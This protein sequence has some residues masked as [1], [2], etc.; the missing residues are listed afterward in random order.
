MTTMKRRNLTFTILI[1]YLMQL[2]LFSALAKTE[3]LIMD[4]DFENGGEWLYGN[5]NYADKIVGIDKCS[6]AAT[7]PQH[8]YIEGYAPES[9]SGDKALYIKNVNPYYPVTFKA[10]LEC[11]QL[12]KLSAWVK[13]ANGEPKMN[14]AAT[15]KT[16][17]WS[18][19]N[20]IFESDDSN[21]E[22]KYSAESIWDD[23][24][25]H[26][27]SVKD[28][29]WTKIERIFYVAED[30]NKTAITAWIG[31]ASYHGGFGYYIDDVS[32]TKAEYEVEIT[33]EENVSIPMFGEDNTIVEYAMSVT[34]GGMN[35]PID[36]S[37]LIGLKESY[38]GVSIENNILTVKD[39]AYE[40]TI[41][42]TASYGGYSKEMP[43][44]LIYNGEKKP[45]ARNV[46]LYSE[47][48]PGNIIKVEYDY[49]DPM[50]ISEAETV[51]EWLGR[52]KLSG[53]W[54]TICKDDGSAITGKEFTVPED[55]LYDAVKVV[56]TVCNA[57]GVWGEKSV[58]NEA[59]KPLAPVAKNVE[60][61]GEAFVGE[62]LRASYEYEDLNL[63]DE[64]ESI[65][66][67]YR[68]DSDQDKWQKIDGENEKEYT[69]KSEDAFMYIKFG[70][71][72]VSVA[73]PFCGEEAFSNIIE[74]P[75]APEAYDVKIMR[76]KNSR[77]LTGSYTYSHKNNVKEGQ[78]IY[79]W[80]CDGQV[81]SNDITYTVPAGI[82]ATVYF[83][84]TPVSEKEPFEGK[85]VK[86]D[87]L[88]FHK[89][90]NTGGSSSGTGSGSGGSGI[91]Q[92]GKPSE[93]ETIISDTVGTPT[94]DTEPMKFSDI[95][96]HWAKD[97][98]NELAEK[99]IINGFDTGVFKP[100]AMV[101][102][103]EFCT[104][105]YRSFVPEKFNGSAIFDDVL[106][107]DWYFEPI[108]SMAEKG[109]VNGYG[110]SFKPNN[111]ISRQEA[112][113]VIWEILGMEAESDAELLYTDVEDISAWAKNAV[114]GLTK[115]EILTGSNGRFRALDMLTRAE[116]AVIV[117]KALDLVK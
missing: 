35:V 59:S 19:G 33:G 83:E 4:G 103:A 6:V 115:L 98:I 8:S 51:I 117:K 18:G 44:K 74:G 67:W 99:K 69:I 36:D 58:S 43:V 50:G 65:Y 111:N 100:D 109:I 53:E 107:N 72:P 15:T 3:N 9:Y 86:S 112:A 16:S 70:V 110:T 114:A 48:L 68:K 17:D 47:L 45:S 41:I 29:E 14:W 66:Q 90:T 92:T 71:I 80:Y 56:V 54:E 73:E 5:G 52:N 39:S 79:K 21:L 63:D 26:F 108:Q 13:A 57:D 25:N 60:V 1:L 91:K 27:V 102:R 38:E 40:Q 49:Y 88:T 76:S 42:L 11:G 96:E 22:K 93:S 105:I 10:S 94:K 30:E 23:F 37:K 75:V 89:T 104:M 95:S 78:S 61:T 34:L 20:N 113:K 116:A 28:N 46:K 81:V 101:T 55:F 31:L 62:I 97:Y 64:G 85:S 84:V 24:A 77:I 106:E 12:Y 2:S 87:S 82:N 32:L 7:W